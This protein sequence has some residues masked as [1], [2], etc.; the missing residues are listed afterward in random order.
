MSCPS[1]KS[2]RTRCEPMKPAM[3]VTMTFMTLRRFWAASTLVELA[4]EGR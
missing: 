3:P 4:I 1:R 2:R